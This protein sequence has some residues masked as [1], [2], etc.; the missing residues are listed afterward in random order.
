MYFLKKDKIGYTFEEWDKLAFNLKKESINLLWLFTHPFYI[1]KKGWVNIQRRLIDFFFEL[2]TNSPLSLNWQPICLFLWINSK[3]FSF[4]KC[5]IKCIFYYT[6]IRYLKLFPFFFFF[7]IF[8]SSIKFHRKKKEYILKTWCSHD[9]R[10]ADRKCVGQTE[11][12]TDK[13]WIPR[14]LWDSIISNKHR[15]PKRYHFTSGY[16]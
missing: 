10:I 13:K 5:T 15:L 11:R 8:I 3:F 9:L 16:R 2:T 4:F 6:L 12:Q 1:L 7:T 14:M